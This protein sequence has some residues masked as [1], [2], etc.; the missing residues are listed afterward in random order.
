MS[1][2]TGNNKHGNSDPKDFSAPFSPE[3]YSPEERD[4]M[5]E[6]WELA[7]RSRPVSPDLTGQEVDQALSEVH[8]R[9]SINKKKARNNKKARNKEETHNKKEISYPAA[10]HPKS[11][12]SRTRQPAEKAGRLRSSP[13]WR[14]WAAAAV[15]LLV[16]GAGLLLTPQTVTAPRGEM[17]SVTLPDGSFVELNSGSRIE[18]N[19]FFAYTNRTIELEGEAFFRVEQDDH[20]FVVNANQSVVK[21]TGTQFNGRAW[22]GELW[23]EAEVTVAEGAVDFYPL[24]LPEQFVTVHGGELSR[25]TAE[26]DRPTA[27]EDVSIDKILGWR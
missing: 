12:H 19:R 10:R 5:M 13:R 4:G 9:I 15:I 27:P 23:K 1:E 8:R 25:W 7:G 16:F 21:V 17:V 22:S 2:P 18:Y 14:W 11:H 6:L 26:M 20:P 24:N 3:K